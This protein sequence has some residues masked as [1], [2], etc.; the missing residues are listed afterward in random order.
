MLQAATRYC[1]QQLADPAEVPLLTASLN[2]FCKCVCHCNHAALIG[3]PAISPRGLPP[4]LPAGVLGGAV[5][6][7]PITALGDATG[8]PLR[9]KVVFT[10]LTLL[11]AGQSVII[12]SR[13]SLPDAMS[14]PAAASRLANCVW[15]CSCQLSGLVG[16]STPGL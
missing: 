14:V 6:A 8:V 4:L 1:T 7:A 5:A 9:L 15:N 2:V 12:S 11:P 10:V 3:T 13:L 16:L